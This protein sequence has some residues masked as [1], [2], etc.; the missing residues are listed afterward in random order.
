MKLKNTS[1]LSEKEK[2]SLNCTSYEDYVAYSTK[3]ALQ[4][5]SDHDLQRSK[6]WKIWVEKFGSFSAGANCFMQDF[7]PI[8]ELARTSGL[9]YNSLAVGTIC[10]LLTVGIRESRIIRCKN[11]C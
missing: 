5:K 7:N 9:Q 4:I 10:M 8:V 2:Q 1:L 3:F 11:G 6:R